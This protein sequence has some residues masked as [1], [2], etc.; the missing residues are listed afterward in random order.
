M[1]A[2]TSPV[3]L[4]LA[5]V[6]GVSAGHAAL[7][8]QQASAN[9]GA[10]LDRQAW[11]ADLDYF[12][13]EFA[14]AH[15]DFAKLYPRER[16]NRDVAAVAEGLSRTRDTDTVLALMRLVASAHV[17]H[18][19]VRF[20]S[21][22]SPIAFH[23]LPLAFNWFSDGLAV[24]GASAQYP[25]AAGLRV[26]RIGTMTPAQ[27]QEAIAPYVAHENPWWLRQQSRTFMIV[28]EML[29]AVGAVR[30][31]G[32]V[33]VRLAR[34][35]GST[36]TLNVDPRPWQDRQ[37]VTAVASLGIP[38]LLAEKDAA[39]YYRYE[40]LPDARA[41][42]VRYSQ[43]QDDPQQPF[44]VFT[45]GL[46][47]KVDADRSAFERVIIDLR[48]NGGGDSRVITPLL[49]GLRARKLTGRDRLVVLTGPATFSSALMAA[50]TL[51]DDLDA[52][53]VGEPPGERPN[54]YGEV[55]Q[56]T[57]PNSQLV[58]QY[59]TKFFR[60]ERNGDPLAL[61]PH[62]TLARS[63]ADFLQGRDT[64]LEAALRR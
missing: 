50:I 2:R 21:P 53:L 45:K 28:Y 58:V 42:Y 11:R 6:A 63:I 34:P 54:S 27:L 1:R 29:R 22:P 61:E 4:A 24:T 57:L 18:T 26:E 31:D 13:R 59:S 64:V 46:F 33:P 36:L 23:R 47:A 38:Q 40:V 32:P 12:T 25:E 20:P 44:V 19:Y 52:L 17:G 14:R 16:F 56:L 10:G 9:P 51:R 39:R 62:I 35:D 5:L 60:M 3:L 8:G 37:I 43:C 41:V 15:V 48:A 30:S 49:D 55:R 7:R